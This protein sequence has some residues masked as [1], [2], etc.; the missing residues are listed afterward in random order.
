MAEKIPPTERVTASF[1]QLAVASS[2]LDNAAKDLGTSISNIE[3]SLRRIGLQVSAWHQVAGHEADS[4]EYWSRDI[5]WTKLK[6]SWGI[7]VR[8]ANGFEPTEDHNEEIWPFADAPRWMA[9]EAASK[10][11][12]LFETLVQ[13]TNE[14]TEKLRRRKTQTDELAAALDGIVEETVAQIAPQKKVKK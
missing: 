6:N 3:A 12:D 9:I 2:D 8:K 14:M 13:R 1:K 4:G 10:L 11:P 5:G 7:A